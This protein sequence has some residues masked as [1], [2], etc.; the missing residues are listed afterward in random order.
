MEYRENLHKILGLDMTRPY[1][2]YANAVKFDNDS[3]TE[4]ILRNPHEAISINDGTFNIVM[5][6]HY[7]ILQYVV[8][9]YIILLFLYLITNFLIRYIKWQSKSTT[10]TRFIYVSSLYAR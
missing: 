2:R 4:S 8:L 10:C 7:I 1:F 9:H 6:S 5:I 3:Q